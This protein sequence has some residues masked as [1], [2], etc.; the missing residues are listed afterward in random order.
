[1]PGPDMSTI[2]PADRK[3]H[4]GFTLVEAVLVIMI[5]GIIAAAVASFMRMPIRGY[6]DTA[7]RVALTDVA[8]TALRRMTRDFKLALPN[9]IRRQ[10]VGGEIFIEFLLT[11][12]GG[13]Y[14]ALEDNATTG[15]ILDFDDASALTFKVVG[16]MPDGIETITERDT[17]VVYNLG[18]GFAPADA[19]QAVNTNRAYVREVNAAASTITLI[20]NPFAV[21]VPQMRSPGHRFQVVT[22][23]V[24]Y[25]CSPATGELT[26]YWGYAIQ[27]IQP[28]NTASGA[29]STGQKAL[30]ATGVSACAFS[31]D[32]LANNPAYQRS[33]LVGIGL[34][35][36]ARESSGGAV[37][38][39]HQVHVDNTP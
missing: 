34:T 23:P 8:D 28:T 1:M 11:K 7:A 15:D 39:F 30:L 33:G 17:V 5:T 29:L 3:R 35:L 36:R 6:V 26:R 18:P 9:S 12:T 27:A 16:S 31:Y 19:Y 14:L 13:R 10:Q 37:S 38:L 4:R 25:H 2:A 22:S 20:S 24:T 32:N 21:Q